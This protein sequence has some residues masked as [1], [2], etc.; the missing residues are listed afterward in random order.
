MICVNQKLFPCQF[1]VQSSKLS[2]VNK[3]NQNT[4]TSPT[5]LNMAFKMIWVL[6][7][8]N[9]LQIRLFFFLFSTGEHVP[10]H[11]EAFKIQGRKTKAT[12]KHCR[13]C[14]IVHTTIFLVFA[15]NVP[16]PIA[17]SRPSVGG[18]VR[19]A[20]GERG[21]IWEGRTARP[22][23]LTLTRLLFRSLLFSFA[24]AN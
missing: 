5:A 22:H 17:R 14:N 24:T 23:S 6:D 18:A 9:S 10:T 7:F 15:P 4:M 20:G 21:K 13:F 8:T 16:I 1:E 19:R 12:I 11:K 3:I 2:K